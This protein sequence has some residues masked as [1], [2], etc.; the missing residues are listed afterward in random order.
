MELLSRVNRKK[1][2][3]YTLIAD[4]LSEAYE[5]Q[6]D[7]EKLNCILKEV[8]TKGIALS[9]FKTRVILAFLKKGNKELLEDY[10]NKVIENNKQSLIKFLVISDEQV[11]KKRHDDRFIFNLPANTHTF[12]I[13]RNMH[14]MSLVS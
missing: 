2:I 11:W 1:R 10:Y 4:E 6:G 5:I 3:D 13:A 9:T 14:Y 8:K 7:F 12:E